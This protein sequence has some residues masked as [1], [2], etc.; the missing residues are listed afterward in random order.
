VGVIVRHTPAIQSIT[1]AAYLAA[2]SF[3]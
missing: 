2:P 1:G 3:A